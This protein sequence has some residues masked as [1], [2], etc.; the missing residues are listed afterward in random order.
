MTHV[1]QKIRLCTAS[2]LSVLLWDS[3]LVICFTK[4]QS[5]CFHLVLKLNIHQV[6][7]SG[8]IFLLPHCS[9]KCDT[10]H[11]CN[12]DEQFN[13]AQHKKSQNPWALKYLEMSNI[14]TAYY[15]MDWPQHFKSFREEPKCSI[16]LCGK[17]GTFKSLSKC[18]SQ[19][20]CNRNVFFTTAS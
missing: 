6:K 12:N 9:R 15:S 11:T 16:L 17:V 20:Q 14:V 19:Q 7:L 4:L 8:E 2:L 1:S 13:L 5:S 10:D 3:E 18:L